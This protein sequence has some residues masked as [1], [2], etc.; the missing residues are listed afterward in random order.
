MIFA[1]GGTGG[2][3]YPG[4]AIAS[5][6]E[7]RRPD[8]D[9]H[10]LGALRGVEA[11]VL[12]S[13]G[14]PH[15]L[16][17]IRGITRHHGVLRNLAVGPALLRSLLGAIELFADLRPALVVLT[18]G[19]ASAPAGMVA[20]LRGTPL[21]LQ[22]QNAHPGLVTRRMATWADQIHVA[23]P[24]AI[25]LLP[26]SARAVVRVTGNPIAPPTEIDPAA[27]RDALG[28]DP[29]RPVVLLVGGSQGSTALNRAVVEMLALAGDAPEW[30]LLWGTG[31]S[32]AEAMTAAWASAGAPAWVHPRGYIDEMPSALRVA[33]IAISRAGAMATSEFLAWGLPAVLVPLPT[34]AADHQAKNATALAAAGCAR[35]L[36]E[37]E[38]DGAS[39]RAAIDALVSDTAARSAMRAAALERARPGAAA[40]VAAALD[41]LLTSTRRAA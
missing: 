1:G 6:L 40:D 11:H 21:V 2:H 28:L 36:P 33:E 19:Y 22:E 7:A 10:F 14:V 26:E 24:E 30:Q 4:L 32:N 20:A 35:L 31:L 16:L 27:A 34:A 5:A 41:Q 25:D 18:G 39:L 8:V 13:R 23:F 29:H 9:V 37:S 38:L 17:P 3:L 12:P 15:T